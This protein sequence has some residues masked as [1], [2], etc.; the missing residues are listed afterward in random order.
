[1]RGTDRAHCHRLLTGL[2]LLMLVSMAAM[3]TLV[4]HTGSRWLDRVSVR[5]R[6]SAILPGITIEGARARQH[7]LVI[8]SVRSDGEAAR[9]GVVVG[10][11]IVEFDGNRAV[12][13]DQARRYLQEDKSS[14]IRLRIMHASRLR[15]IRLDRERDR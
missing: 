9:A 13:L 11:T 10:D 5:S 7:G 8:T 2:I 12:S 15:D 14:R 4:S 1:M 3:L 6:A